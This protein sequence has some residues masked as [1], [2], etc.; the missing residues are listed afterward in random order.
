MRND[1]KLTAS[2]AP[3]VRTVRIPPQAAAAAALA[4]TQTISAPPIGTAPADTPNAPGPSVATTEPAASAAAD[5]GSILDTAASRRAIRASARAP[6][7]TAEIARTAGTAPAADASERM[8]GAIRSAGKGDCA[9]GD[10]PGAGMGLLSLPFLAA[11]V[12]RGDC[13]AQ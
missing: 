8:G 1:G 2:T 12:A 13:S 4:D 10:Y 3:A 9:K 6:S 5:V 11:A 7:I